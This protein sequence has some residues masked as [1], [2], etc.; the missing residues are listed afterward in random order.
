ML[1][2]HRKERQ[3]AR[4]VAPEAR[5]AAARR[6][7][8]ERAALRAQQTAARKRDERQRTTGIAGATRG[9]R[10]AVISGV[11]TAAETLRQTRG[12][13]CPTGLARRAIFGYGGLFLP[14]PAT[15]AAEGAKTT[16]DSI[17]QRAQTVREHRER[18]LELRRKRE[19]AEAA[20]AANSEEPTVTAVKIVPEGLVN[21]ERA[22]IEEAV[23]VAEEATIVL[24]LKEEQATEIEALVEDAKDRLEEGKSTLPD[25]TKLT[26]E[27][28]ELQEQI[29]QLTGALADAKLEH[30]SAAASAAEANQAEVTMLKAEIERLNALLGTN[31]E[32]GDVVDD[33]VN[34]YEDDVVV[35]EEDIAD[36][37]AAMEEAQADIDDVAEEAADTSA[38]IMETE[39]FHVRHRNVLLL[40][41]AA[42]IGVGYWLWKRHKAR[43]PMAAN[44]GYYNLPEPTTPRRPSGL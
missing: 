20:I 25:E 22:K 15:T 41:G 6:R 11:R 7:V 16:A 44:D 13:P 39:P 8:A 2:R 19:A 9:I 5:I 30:E 43:A 3:A 37:E 32:L 38:E 36:A 21:Q 28:K 26:Q 42:A 18:M 12:V 23:R 10:A 33:Y 1:E 24:N 40:G 4:S 31:P 14:M 29:D 34:M 27:L 17:R 35:A